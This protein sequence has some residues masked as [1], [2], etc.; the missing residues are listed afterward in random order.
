MELLKFHGIPWNFYSRCGD[1]ME[2]HGI[3]WNLVLAS[4]SMELSK[5][6]GI[7][8]N[9]WRV[10][11]NSMELWNID[12]NKFHNR[13]SVF[14]CFLYDFMSLY[15]RQSISSWNIEIFQFQSN[16]LVPFILDKWRYSILNGGLLYLKY[17][18]TL[19]SRNCPD[20]SFF[21][22]K[23]CSE[24]PTRVCHD[25]S[26]FKKH[27]SRKMSIPLQPP[28]PTFHKN[29][30]QWSSPTV[31]MLSGTHFIQENSSRD[32]LSFFYA[33]SWEFI[34]FK[35]TIFVSHIYISAYASYIHGEV[36]HSA[37]AHQTNIFFISDERK[38]T[39]SRGLPIPEAV[40]I[41]AKP[42]KYA[43]R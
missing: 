4:S 37:V 16:F 21:S 8:W 9:F 23:P 43:L 41:S 19:F 40:M 36:G 10:P 26:I 13:G 6:H 30:I 34:F 28:P 11:W 12:I 22:Q 18:L 27:Y 29:D 35:T 24:I 25:I 38:V 1:S 39:S 3:P 33:R 32:W 14:H 5:F 7:P 17:I 15:I 31:A 42:G 20:D 2:F